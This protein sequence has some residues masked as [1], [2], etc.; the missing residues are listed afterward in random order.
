M[1]RPTHQIRGLKVQP[2]EIDTHQPVARFMITLFN[3]FEDEIII[4]LS[5]FSYSDI[6]RTDL[7]TIRYVNE[8]GITVGQLA[9]LNGVSKQAVSKQIEDLV[10]RG[11][12]QK[13]ADENDARIVRVRFSSSGIRLLNKLIE[14]IGGIEAKYQKKIGK[15]AYDRLKRDLGSLLDLYVRG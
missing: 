13:S 1:K 10:K 8:A 11:Y 14:I 2:Q 9:R 7:N 6:N 5:K 4:A 3:F 12:L 15:T